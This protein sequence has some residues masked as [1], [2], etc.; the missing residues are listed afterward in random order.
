MRPI[1]QKLL[2]FAQFGGNLKQF[3]DTGEQENI[4]ENRH[5]LAKNRVENAH[6]G[7][8]HG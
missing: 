5:D 6:T 1:L 3:I 4:R 8:L 2:D 7:L